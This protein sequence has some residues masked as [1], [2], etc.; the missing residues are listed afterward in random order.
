MIVITIP[1]LAL[2][3]SNNRFKISGCG[4]ENANMEFSAPTPESRWPEIDEFI[5]KVCVHE[6]MCV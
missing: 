5:L 3:S 4:T 6:C 1:D 2:N